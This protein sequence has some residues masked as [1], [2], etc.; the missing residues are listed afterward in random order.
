MRVEIDHVL[1]QSCRGASLIFSSLSCV[2]GQQALLDET[3]LPD[4][5]N[6]DYY[7]SSKLQSFILGV[8]KRYK[9]LM[10][11]TPPPRMLNKR[12]SLTTSQC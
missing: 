3:A 7:D 9:S 2:F 11:V 12:S 4:F 5:D 6:L 10:Q 1:Q 8:G